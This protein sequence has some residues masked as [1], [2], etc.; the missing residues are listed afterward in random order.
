M[1][2]YV[3]TRNII[4]SQISSFTLITKSFLTTTTKVLGSLDDRI[5][6]TLPIYNPIPSEMKVDGATTSS[7]ISLESLPEI[8]IQ[9]IFEYLCVTKRRLVLGLCT[10]LWEIQSSLET[11]LQSLTIHPKDAQALLHS[12]SFS[13]LQNIHSNPRLKFFRNLSNLMSL[14]LQSNCND[15]FLQIIPEYQLL[16]N[17]KKMS[18]VRSL[19][20]TDDGL[21][22]LSRGIYSDTLEQ[23]DITHCRNTSYAGT[24]PLRE[25]QPNLKLLRRQP[26]WLDGKLITPFGAAGNGEVEVH[27]YWPDGTF[28]FNRD[29]QS[30]GFVCDLQDWG[31]DYL[32]DKLQYNN[33]ASPL[34]WPEWTR[35]CY[36]PGVCLLRLP[37]EEQCEEEES[38]H[39]TSG[40]R[41]SPSCILVG[42][43]LRG[44][45]P[46]RNRA[47]ME[48]AR[49]MVAMGESKYFDNTDGS[50]LEE[51]PEGGDAILIS[52]MRVYPLNDNSSDRRTTCSTMPPNELVEICRATCQEMRAFGSAA[53]LAMKEEELQIF[54]TKDL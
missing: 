1:V 9:E 41:L 54:L 32:G 53:F 25:R 36:R 46:P 22:C 45:R 12:L 5:V 16:P 49:S 48:R 30:N 8:L 2:G 42:Q 18:M 33:F 15:E 11:N 3:R 10:S 35:Y 37:P 29:S 47:L 14:D 28:T 52:K 51:A 7:T 13:R 24:F 20:V 39:G 38:D 26:E 23:I 21:E 17:L 27:T 6:T 19:G 40:P 43:H 31:E 50:L 4:R 44:L 34:G